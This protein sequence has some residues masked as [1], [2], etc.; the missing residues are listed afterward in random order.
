MIEERISKVEQ[1]LYTILQ[2]IPVPEYKGEFVNISDQVTQISQRLVDGGSADLT[3]KLNRQFD[4]R[5]Y[6]MKKTIEN[7]YYTKISLV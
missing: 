5:L 1:Q 7:D 2:Y 3:G 4:E 6:S